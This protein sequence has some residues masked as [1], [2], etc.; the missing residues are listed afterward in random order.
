MPQ[1]FYVYILQNESDPD[2]FYTGCTRDLRNRLEKHNAGA[3]AHTAKY[4]PWGLK[5]YVAFSDESQAREFEHYLKS[6]LGRAF[7]RKRL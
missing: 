1:F 7:A 6:S 2:R 5:T 4:R 3:V